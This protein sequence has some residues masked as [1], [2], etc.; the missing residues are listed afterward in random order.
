MPKTKTISEF[1]TLQNKVK[2]ILARAIQLKKMQEDQLLACLYI[3]SQAKS[4]YELEAFINIFEDAFPVLKEISEQ[5]TE[6]DK[7]SLEAKIR[8]A[9][10]KIVKTAPLK[11]TEIAKAAIEPGMTWEKLTARYP[12]LK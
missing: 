10:G 5:K 8:A 1:Q 4:Q 6:T 7:E 2:F 12:E 3:L 11:A 9:L